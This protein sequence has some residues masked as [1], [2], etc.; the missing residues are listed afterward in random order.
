MTS[1]YNRSNITICPIYYEDTDFTG[2]VYHANYLKF[3]ERAREHLIGI[4]KL[5]ELY[6]NNLHFVV[7]EININYRQPAGHGDFLAI[8]TDLISSGGAKLKL[9]QQAWKIDEKVAHKLH[10]ENSAADQQQLESL[11]NRDSLICNAEIKIV[12][13]NEFGRPRK[14]TPADLAPFNS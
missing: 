3:F 4:Q 10:S 12:A 14:L 5:R 13:V 6:A 8:T 9:D 11:R 1:P 2:Y 7:S